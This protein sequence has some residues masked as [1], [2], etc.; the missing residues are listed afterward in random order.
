MTGRLNGFAARLLIG[1]GLLGSF[2]VTSFGALL[3]G[4]T[5]TTEFNF[6]TIGTIG[7]GGV[8][9]DRVVGP[10]TEIFASPQGFPIT[11]I[12]FSDT[13]IL[14]TFTASLMGSPG[15]FNGWIFYDN[16]NNIPAFTGASLLQGPGVSG[17]TVSFD[18]DHI[19]LNGQS[20]IY[21]AG[22]TLQ[23]DLAE[24]SPIPEPSTGVLIA[25]GG[26]LIL[27]RS[28]RARRYMR[29]IPGRRLRSRSGA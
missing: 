17:W 9:V 12:D 16:L 7:F 1:G 11:D 24:P 19:Y 29:S 4:T 10:G 26:L 22:S 18:S 20:S 2:A 25:F 28:T 21:T 27:G 5:I 23:V 13:S 8:P 15:A 3:D 14:L 6:P